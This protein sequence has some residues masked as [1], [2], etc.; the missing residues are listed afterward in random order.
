MQHQGP[1]HV[2]TAGR[3]LVVSQGLLKVSHADRACTHPDRSSSR[4]SHSSRRACSVSSSTAVSSWRSTEVKGARIS[5]HSCRNASSAETPI[6]TSTW[7]GARRSAQRRCVL[8]TSTNRIV[9]TGKTQGCPGQNYGRRRR[10]KS[11]WGAGLRPPQAAEEFWGSGITAASGGR[12]AFFTPL[13]TV[14][15]HYVRH[16]VVC[17]RLTVKFWSAVRQ[18]A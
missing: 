1:K 9:Y 10:P 15:A 7:S 16:A 6:S 4:P 8:C 14:R 17:N 18:L 13:C 12:R 3:K 11:F 2:Q 5:A